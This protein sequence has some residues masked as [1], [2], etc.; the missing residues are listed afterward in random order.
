M[1]KEVKQFTLAVQGIRRDGVEEPLGNQSCTTNKEVH[2]KVYLAGSFA[3]KDQ[4]KTKSHQQQL[5]WAAQIL[6]SKGLEVYLPQE[7]HIHNA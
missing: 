2:M 1:N 3:Y 4:A 5:E 7:L 6:K